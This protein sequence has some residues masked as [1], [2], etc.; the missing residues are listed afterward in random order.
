M[1]ATTQQGIRHSSI[2]S[3][4]TH[5]VLRFAFG[6]TLAF[7]TAQL[8]EWTP[9]F[10][11]PVMVAVLLVSIPIRPPIKLGVGLIVIV[12]ASALVAL[13]LT[14]TL[15]GMPEIL[16]G[17]TALI[18]FR[19][20]YAVAQGRPAIGPLMLIICVTVIPVLGVQSWPVAT[21]FAYAFVQATCFGIL[22]A[23]IAH[24]IWPRVMQ[25]RASVAAT[26]LSSE[27]AL[28]S[29][30]MGTAIMMPVMLVYLMFGLTDGLPVLTTTAM[31]VLAMDYQRGR[32]QALALV[33]ANMAGG[34]ASLLLMMLLVG[35]PS[36][37]TLT[38]II[39]GAAL[40]FG[41]GITSGSPMA[42]AVLPTAFNATLIVFT[43][44]LLSEDGTFFLWVKRL[45]Q[46]LIA[47]A[48]AIGMMTLLWP[49]KSDERTIQTPESLP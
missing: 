27:L 48:F 32:R 17:I 19:G 38:L 21:T 10:L 3:A 28:K 8:M 11:A 4:R 34:L 45:S 16:F 35:H 23:W 43:S 47:G 49:R 7:M 14:A 42:A 30:L 5:T 24:L 33:L 26:P 41:W 12:S 22:I 25:P 36:I 9:A 29:A 1:N 39:L 6:V 31:I 20:L 40:V 15:R 13:V 44:S 46:F 2:N 37:T 18:V